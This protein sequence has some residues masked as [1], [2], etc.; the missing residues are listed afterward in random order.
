[1]GRVVGMWPGRFSYFFLYLPQNQESDYYKPENVQLM[2]SLFFVSKIVAIL[3]TDFSQNS[4]IFPATFQVFFFAEKPDSDHYRY[5]FL[6]LAKSVHPFWSDGFMNE[7]HLIFIYI[8][9]NN[10]TSRWYFI[11]D[12]G[13]SCL[14]K[15][16]PQSRKI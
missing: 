11:F 15:M 14:Q 1:M 13:S 7:R 16:V 12:C 2:H 4:T 8:D 3:T 9:V 6:K 10:E 5:F